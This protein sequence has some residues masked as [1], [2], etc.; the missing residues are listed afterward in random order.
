[1]QAGEQSDQGAAFSLLCACENPLVLRTAWVP[2]CSL[3]PHTPVLPSEAG[4]CHQQHHS[5]VPSRHLSLAQQKPSRG[6]HLPIHSAPLPGT[7]R[8]G[9]QGPHRQLAHGV[10]PA[11]GVAEQ[12]GRHVAAA[13]AHGVLEESEGRGQRISPLPRAGCGG[14]Q[15]NAAQAFSQRQDGGEEVTPSEQC[16]PNTRR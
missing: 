2:R 12:P 13:R 9:S 3:S 11:P 1:M 10:C 4:T 8:Q 6:H 16:H 5:H 14:L 15:Q 7:P